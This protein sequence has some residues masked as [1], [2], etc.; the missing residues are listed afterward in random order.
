MEKRIWIL[1]FQGWATAPQMVKKCLA[2][3]QKHNPGWEIQCLD[4]KNLNR[5]VTLDPVLVNKKIS[6]AALSDIIRIQLLERHGGVWV[7]STVWCHQPLDEWLDKV[8]IEGFFAFEKPAA[9]RLVSSWFLAA[10][11]YNYIIKQWARKV[12]AYWANRDTNH[13]YFWFHHLFGEL[14]HL[15]PVFDQ[16]WNRVP[17]ISAV[18]LHVLQYNI[19]KPLSQLTRDLVDT[20][21]IP[22]SKLTYKYSGW[23]DNS[24]LAY[25]FKA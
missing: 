9:D 8:M 17:K 13:H 7:D 14:T 2:S 24:G 4:E 6:L 3:W 5:F 11:P 12:T 21:Q 19:L 16:I 15:D 25:L 22:V 20:P 10:T 23:D 1:W 18:Q